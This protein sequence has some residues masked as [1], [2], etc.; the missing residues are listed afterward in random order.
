MMIA[1]GGNPEDG[2]PFK[3]QAGDEDSQILDEAVGLQALMGEQAVV[4]KGNAEAPGGKSQHAKG[5]KPG[6]GKGK[7][8]ENAKEMEEGDN[9]EGRPGEVLVFG[10]FS[11]L[12]QEN[13]PLNP[14]HKHGEHLKTG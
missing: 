5:D 7:Q 4:A 10:K 3:G 8:G 14:C 6:P 1:V 12:K 11:K 9:Q 2:T 13:N